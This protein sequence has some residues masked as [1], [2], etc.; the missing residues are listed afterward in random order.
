MNEHPE[1]PA[2]FIAFC[3]T[4]ISKHASHWPPEESKLADEFITH[5]GLTAIANFDKQIEFCESLGIHVSEKLLPE[6][7]RG[8]NCCYRNERQ[9]QISPGKLYLI[10]REHTLLH[11]L[12][13]ILEYIF[14]DLG[15]PTTKEM[16]T[17][18]ARAETFA[19]CVRIGALAETWET[20]IRAVPQ[21]E[22]KWWRLG[23]SFLFFL[24]GIAGLFS[25]AILPAFEDRIDP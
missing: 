3:R 1:Y 23:A 4:V 2:A 8:H 13:E 22:S 14:K 18:E 19:S 9:I 5:F 7:L 12:R 10:S 25:I 16:S 6:S 20:I 11:E 21:I 15:F 24:L 17:L